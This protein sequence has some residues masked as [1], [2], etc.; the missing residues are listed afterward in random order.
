MIQGLE[1]FEIKR[2]NRVR[3]MK[4]RQR[5]ILVLLAFFMVLMMTCTACKSGADEGKTTEE[6]T[7]APSTEESTEAEETEPEE[8]S[9]S[10]QVSA[11]DGDKNATYL[12]KYGLTTYKT[13][14]AEL[15]AINNVRYIDI[16]D[17]AEIYKGGVFCGWFAA[18]D[19]SDVAD[20]PDMGDVIGEDNVADYIELRFSGIDSKGCEL[21]GTETLSDGVTRYDFEVN[22][23]IQN[24]RSWLVENGF[25]TSEAKL[26]E[27]ETFP[28]SVSVYCAEDSNYGYVLCLE[29]DQ[30]S[31][32]MVEKLAEAV[33]FKKSSFTETRRLVPEGQPAQMLYQVV[34]NQFVFVKDYEQMCQWFSDYNG[35]KVQRIAGADDDNYSPAT[36]PDIIFYRANSYETKEEVVNAMF[37]AIME[38]LTEK[39]ASRPFVVTQYSLE[40]QQIQIYAGEENMWLLP[41]LNGYYAYTGTDGVTMETALNGGD[42]I[43]GMVPFFRQGSSESFQFILIKEGNV[44]RLQRAVDMGLEVKSYEK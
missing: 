31:D 32:R 15:A 37:R 11:F 38:P 42:V 4:M 9:N 30:L 7:T 34:E 35:E 5:K 2:L 40:E 24:S 19:F 23:A 20:I 36:C 21:T 28:L 6:I 3:R 18:W 27:R 33:S 26:L 41:M 22:T 43:N 29:T 44:Y 16:G 39:S 8:T 14:L 12:K 10:L 13:S 25:Y 17:G 1:L